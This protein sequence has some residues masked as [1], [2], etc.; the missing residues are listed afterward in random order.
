M[1]SHHPCVLLSLLLLTGAVAVGTPVTAPDVAEALKQSEA[2]P[3]EEQIR[4]LGKL[5]LDLR[6]QTS[7]P[8]S[9][10]VEAQSAKVRERLLM[11]P[12]HAIHFGFHIRKRRVEAVT[13]PEKYPDYEAYAVEAFRILELMPS[14]ETVAVVSSFLDDSW[15]PHDA[16]DAGNPSINAQRILGS[17]LRNPPKTEGPFDVPSWMSWRKGMDSGTHSFMLKGSDKRFNFRGPVAAAGE[18][19]PGGI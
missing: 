5:L 4:I 15:N 14:A 17:I 16:S 10:E 2:L 1:S 12:G 7:E 13:Y 11:I 3:S 19:R 9:Q 6:P 18:A 8:A